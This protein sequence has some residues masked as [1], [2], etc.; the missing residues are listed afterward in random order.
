M[1]AKAGTLRPDWKYELWEPDRDLRRNEPSLDRL[2]KRPFEMYCWWSD[3]S[4]GLQQPREE[5]S[6]RCR[7]C[8]GGQRTRARLSLVE[9]PPFAEGLHDRFFLRGDAVG[10]ELQTVTR[11][12]RGAHL[13]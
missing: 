5:D 1:A 12:D 4:S 10:W 8:G 7:T 2:Q 13:P 6:G 11:S 3:H 9:H